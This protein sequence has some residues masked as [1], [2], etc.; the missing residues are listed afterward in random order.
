MGALTEK[1]DGRKQVSSLAI[2]FVK[3][4]HFFQL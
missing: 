3:N 1:T 2:H 4:I